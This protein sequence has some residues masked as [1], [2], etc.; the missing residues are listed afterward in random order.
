MKD[1]PTGIDYLEQMLNWDKFCKAHPN[2]PVALREILDELY[3]LREEVARGGYKMKKIL[4]CILHNRKVII[5]GIAIGTVALVAY[6]LAHKA[7]TEWRGYD[8]IGGEMFIPL[9]IIFAEDIWEMIK[10]P[11]K[12]VKEN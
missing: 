7:G 8:A 10:A 1:N 2:F 3:A 11:F 9:L 4:R 12:A 5:K 6:Q